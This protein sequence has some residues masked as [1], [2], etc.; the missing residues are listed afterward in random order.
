MNPHS[1]LYGIISLVL[2]T[3]LMSF[4]WPL[5]GQFGHE[6]GAA[7]TGAIAGSLVTIL[8]PWKNFRASFAQAVFF[9]TLGFAAGGENIPYG[10][11]VDSLLQQPNL[12]AAFPQLLAILFIG[13]SWGGIGA[14][15]LGYGIAEKPMKIG[16]YALII[17]MGILALF[18]I[19]YFDSNPVTA[20][21]LTIL[22]LLLQA[23]NH[24][25]KRSRAVRIFGIAGLLGFGLG[26]LGAVVI[27]FLGSKGLLPGPSHWWALRDQMWGGTGGFA[28]GVAACRLS[29]KTGRPVPIAPTPFQRL[30]FLLFVPFICGINTWD[31]YQKWFKSTPPAP[32]LTLAGILIVGGTAL[33]ILSFIYYLV[34]NPQTFSAPRLN[35]T[36]L[37]A[38]LFFSFYLTFFGIAKSVVYSGWGVWEPAFTFFLCE[39]LLF[40]V[41]LPFILLG[42]ENP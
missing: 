40:F 6:W 32:N 31:V 2:S 35:G 18:F 41:T 15:Y 26:S 22:F 42:P 16:D 33:L 1:L 20:V 28:L 17:L 36:I 38:F 8:L 19:F 39:S 3:I 34:S 27:L 25:F 29:A 30:G 14:T 9:G 13:A 24:L 12:Q 5:R 21:T 7:I 10:A 37:A 11:I 4:A 23:Y